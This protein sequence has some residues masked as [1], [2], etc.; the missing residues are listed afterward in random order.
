MILRIYIYDL[1]SGHTRDLIIIKQSGNT[2]A[3]RFKKVRQKR[4]RFLVP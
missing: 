1:E 4:K 3:S 2:N